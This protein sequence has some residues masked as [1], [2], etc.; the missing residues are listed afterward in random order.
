LEEARLTI[1]AALDDVL[2]DARE[3]GTGLTRQWSCEGGGEQLSSV[4]CR[5]G[6]GDRRVSTQ[7]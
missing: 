3:V 1:V 5:R 6:I 7:K 4:A 2:R